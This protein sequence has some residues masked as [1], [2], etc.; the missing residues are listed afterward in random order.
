MKRLYFWAMMKTTIFLAISLLL[1]TVLSAQLQD[2]FSDGDFTNDPEWLGQTEKFAIVD[3]ALQLLDENAMSSNEAYLYTAAATSSDA[4]TKWEFWVKMDFNP[5][6]DNYTRVYLNASSPNLLGDLNGY[7]IRIG[8]S[9]SNDA[10]ELIRQDGSSS[11]T[12]LSGTAEAVASNPIVRISVSRSTAGVWNL[13]ADYTG[14]TD[15]QDEG[16]V[17]DSTYPTGGFFGFVCTYTTTRNEDFT[18]DDILVDPLFIDNTPPLLL[19]ASAENATEVLLTFNELLDPISAENPANY[20]VDGGIGNPSSA[21]IDP[22]N[23]TIVQL[24]LSSSLISTTDYVVSCNNISDEKGNVASTLSADFSYIDIQSASFQD[25]I[26]T[27]IMF[28]P[29]PVIEL[30]N[31]EYIELYNRSDK[32]IELSTLFFFIW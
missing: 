20:L 26:I 10:L 11:E 28:D 18:F 17:T 16:S 23:P 6:N 14:G 32:I 22:S 13:M 30:P 27:E 2:D 12:L 7:Y 24:E 15:Y 19:S 8:R 9:G 29:N 25:I 1:C 5:S 3:N 4:S 21:T 31:G